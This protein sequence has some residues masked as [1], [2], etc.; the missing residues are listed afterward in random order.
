[1]A[2]PEAAMHED[3]EAVFWKHDIWTAGQVRP[4]K[5]E[6]IAETVCDLPDGKFRRGVL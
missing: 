1:M 5:S 3:R 2:M 4:V 6:S